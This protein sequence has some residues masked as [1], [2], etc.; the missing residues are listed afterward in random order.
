MKFVLAP[1]SYKGTLSQMDV[2]QV[3]KQA[4]LNRY[5]NSKVITKP[6]ADGGEG[7]LDALLDAADQG[8]RIP[9]Q[10]TGPL[11]EQI[12]T[13]IGVVNE[14][15]AVIEVAAI[16]GLPFV[17]EALRNPMETTTYGIGEAIGIVLDRGIR[18]FVIGLGGSATNDGGFGML[19][20]LGVT[21]EASE[22]KAL[23]MK[24]KGLLDIQTID[25]HTIDSRIWD[26]EIQIAS[27]VDNPLYGPNGATYIFG[28]QKGATSEQMAKLDTAMNKYSQLAE[29]ALDLKEALVNFPGAGAAG[30][31]GFAFLLLQAEIISGAKLVAKTIELEKEI[32]DADLVFTGE[33][34]SDEQTLFGK[35]PG[36][37]AELARKHGV[38]VYLVS[39]SVEDEDG[40]LQEYF[41]EIFSL[42]DGKISLQQALKQTNMVLL[43]KMKQIL[44][45]K[46]HD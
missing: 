13:S 8:E 38:K 26:C 30:G 46:A 18:K 14:D 32:A 36:Y 25:F 19:A 42:V 27:D 41:S 33:G 5:P 45:G 11:G 28:P 40:K 31:L 21:I 2:S 44:G 39:G 16:A 37:V 23:S 1:D 6:M 24:G 35:A 22:N 12:D 20:A 15:T 17:P 4:I 7:T 34:K 29:N 10:V 9:V 43:E 3:M